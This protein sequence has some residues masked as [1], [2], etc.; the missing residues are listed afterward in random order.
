MVFRS[1]P[2][3]HQGICIITGADFLELCLTSEDMGLGLGLIE[4]SW[5]DPR[6]T[7][8]I[9]SEIKGAQNQ[10]HRVGV[11]ILN[12]SKRIVEQEYI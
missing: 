1:S 12:P 10:R 2:G 4:V 7:L 5:L 11:K 3:L 8:I 9:P 6:H